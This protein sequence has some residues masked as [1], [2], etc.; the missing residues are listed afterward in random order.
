MRTFRRLIFWA[1]PVIG[2]GLGYAWAYIDF[3]GLLKSWQLAGRPAENV[4]R[5]VGI[6]TGPE[7]LV[8]SQTGRL[9]S[10]AWN[11][12][13]ETA[14]PSQISWENVAEEE[15]KM[16][17]AKDWGAD[18]A[19]LPPPFP[20]EQLYETEYLYKVEGKGELRAALDK[21]GNIWVW[22]HQSAGLAGVV[23]TFYPVYGFLIGLLIALAVSGINSFTGR[24]RLVPQEG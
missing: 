19:A 21:D 10:L 4:A 1:L 3:H 15:V 22:N 11:F 7:L 18:Y 23:F 17:A 8:E 5:I 9:Y 6:K 24:R 2:M 20:V 16:V 13:K 12:S 14:L